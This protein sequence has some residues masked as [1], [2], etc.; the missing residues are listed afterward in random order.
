MNK[1]H[2]FCTLVS[3]N[4]I[5]HFCTLMNSIPYKINQIARARLLFVPYVFFMYSIEYIK[6]IFHIL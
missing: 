2:H 1:S 5:Y 6:D 4:K 3:V